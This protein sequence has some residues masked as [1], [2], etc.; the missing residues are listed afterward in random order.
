[1]KQAGGLHVF[2]F[3][4]MHGSG[5]KNKLSI[6]F[7]TKQR[8]EQQEKV[9]TSMMKFAYPIHFPPPKK[10]IAILILHNHDHSYYL[11]ER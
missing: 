4:C 1:M 10:N 9:S 11:A 6:H 3:T 7:H 2:W 8:D 5:K